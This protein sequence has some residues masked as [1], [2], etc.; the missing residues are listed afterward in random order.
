LGDETVREARYGETCFGP[1]EMPAQGGPNPPPYRAL[2]AAL[3]CHY[4]LL[5]PPSGV[6][7]TSRSIPSNV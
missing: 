2:I 3:A 5:F 7:I 4:G 1:A 6:L